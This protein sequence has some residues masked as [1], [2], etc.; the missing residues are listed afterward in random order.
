MR[1]TIKVEMQNVGAVSAE[2]EAESFSAQTFSHAVAELKSLAPPTLAKL[3][4][5]KQEIAGEAEITRF[6]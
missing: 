2:L 5:L 3:A 1:I 6:P 4:E